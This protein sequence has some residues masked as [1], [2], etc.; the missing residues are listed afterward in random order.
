MGNS[1][2][3][4]RSVP[5]VMRID[6]QAMPGLALEIARI[7]LEANKVDVGPS[8][9]SLAK[10]RI[11]VDD[12]A[13]MQLHFGPFPASNI[14]SAADLLKLARTRVNSE[15][16]G[17]PEVAVELM[18]AIGQSMV[19]QGLTAEAAALL[20]QERA[21]I[22]RALACLS[23]QERRALVLRDLEELPTAEVARILGSSPTT[24]RSQISMA[25]AKIR[26]FRERW[27]NAKG[28]C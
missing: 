15:T 17:R 20:M 10:R 4:I 23:E 25:R 1:D 27:L 19:G 18:T 22:Q 11:P 9:L 14:V 5:L 6:G 13:R 7:K 3:V 21:L 26:A 28:K 12:Q 24:V 8:A 2:G 16:G